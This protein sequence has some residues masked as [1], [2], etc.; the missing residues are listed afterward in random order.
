MTIVG[1]C[2]EIT[3]F[4]ILF[5]F[6]FFFSAA[7]PM[8][9]HGDGTGVAHQATYSDRFFYPDFPPKTKTTRRS[10]RN[11]AAAEVKKKH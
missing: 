2:F 3:E 11:K 1:L 4:K 9:V 8:S 6:F 7:M 10:K 5:A